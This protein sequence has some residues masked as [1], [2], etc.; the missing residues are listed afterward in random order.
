MVDTMLDPRRLLLLYNQA[1]SGQNARGKEQLPLWSEEIPKR[2][3][4]MP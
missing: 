1:A 4:V 2:V 3:Q